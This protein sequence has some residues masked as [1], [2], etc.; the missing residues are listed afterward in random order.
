MTNRPLQQECVTE[1]REELHDM[2]SFRVRVAF[3]YSSW[4]A[5]KEGG[6]EPDASALEDV[7]LAEAEEDEDT[8][9]EVGSERDAG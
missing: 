2:V 3:Q 7:S 9:G 1:R 6:W 8:A 4:V 5:A